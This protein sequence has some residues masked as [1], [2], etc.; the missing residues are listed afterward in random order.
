LENPYQNCYVFQN[1]ILDKCIHLV[2]NLEN[3][4]C[5]IVFNHT[6][7]EMIEIFNQTFLNE[8]LICSYGYRY[9]KD[10][11]N[12]VEEPFTDLHIYIKINPEK[13]FER[14]QKRYKNDVMLT[15]EFFTKLDKLLY[16]HYKEIKGKKIIL[17]DGYP[18]PI[19]DVLSEI[20]H[21]FQPY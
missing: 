1:K 17:F 2:N 18:I 9:L 21:H 13:C 8:K 16:N 6:P 11:M 20:K 12:C 5:G 4:K 10:K 14:I 3:S 15:K 19:Y 7:L